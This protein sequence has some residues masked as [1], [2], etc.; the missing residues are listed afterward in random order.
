M[1]SCSAT[2]AALASDVEAMTKSKIYFGE[3]V[4]RSGF[5]DE[6]RALSGSAEE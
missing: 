4:V 1:G 3:N 2:A 5:E 6:C